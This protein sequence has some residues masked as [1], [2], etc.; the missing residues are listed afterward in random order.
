MEIE[1]VI[2]DIM[3]EFSFRKA[4]DKVRINGYDINNNINAFYKTEEIHMSSYTHIKYGLARL[5]IQL[6]NTHLIVA[7]PSWFSEFNIQKFS[8]LENFEDELRFSVE[9]YATDISPKYD[10]YKKY[11][12]IGTPYSEY[13]K[14]F[15]YIKDMRDRPRASVM[16]NTS[17]QTPNKYV[18]MYAFGPFSHFGREN[19]VM[20]FDGEYVI[21][22]YTTQREPCD[23]TSGSTEYHNKMHLLNTKALNYYASTM[24]KT[25]R[26]YLQLQKDKRNAPPIS[27][28][29]C[30]EILLKS[31]KGKKT[32]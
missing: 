6:T 18:G 28:N 31:K 20:G 15:H 32:K 1:R 10:I 9:K 17:I 21:E 11:L 14:R 27:K 23:F 24:N 26:A 7:A 8:L 22:M 2:Q 25:K 19:L 12:Q 30:A 5:C 4:V 13:F 16:F 29:P 3:N